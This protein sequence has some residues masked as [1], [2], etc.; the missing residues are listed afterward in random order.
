MISKRSFH[1][2]AAM[3]CL[4]FV[5]PVAFADADYPN[6]P[7]RLVLTV[8][9]GGSINT[10]ARLVGEEMSRTFGQSV[11]VDNRPGA[12]GAI[13]ATLVARAT[14]DGHTLLVSG[15]NTLT[16][17]PYMQG[18][19]NIG[20]DPLKSFVAVS[21]TVRTNYILVVHPKLGVDSVES[22]VALAR[23]RPGQLTYASSG[24][25]SLIHLATEL[26]GE[27]TGT[28]AV[29]VPYKG[30]APALQDLLAGRVDFMFDSATTLGHIQ[31]GRLKGLA[32]VGPNRLGALPQ[33]A[34]LAEHGVH[35]MEGVTG[36]H[37]WF[38]PAGTPPA[39]V[40][41]I[42]AEVG[43]ILAMSTVAERI[44]AQGA[45]PMHMAPAAFEQRVAGDI[46]RL[47]VLLQRL[48]LSAY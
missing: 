21:P 30:L 27:K 40:R 45:E 41:R 29:H 7:I 8:A 10:V 32:V 44:V 37:G 12:A 24:T 38:A 16:L 13:A 19:R 20:Y 35:G 4:A 17:I 46:E 34:P 26:F 14:P 3:S 22:F 47:R 9:A 39:I 2:L 28:K 36:W 1:V 23:S 33:L 31:A 6:R 25:G 43:R 11:V 42:N 48:G 5:S 18:N 15:S